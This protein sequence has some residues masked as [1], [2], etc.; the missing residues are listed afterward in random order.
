MTQVYQIFAQ[1]RHP[2]FIVKAA[3]EAPTR[4][5][6]LA[7]VEENMAAGTASSYTII[8]EGFVNAPEA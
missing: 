8:S 3:F 2:K 1:F 4:E 5:L 6:A 7:K